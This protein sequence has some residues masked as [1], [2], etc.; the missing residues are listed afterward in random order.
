MRKSNWI[1]L[2]RKF[3]GFISFKWRLNNKI[4]IKNKNLKVNNNNNIS[5]KKIIKRIKKGN[6]EIISKLNKSKKDKNI[7]ALKVLLLNIKK[8]KK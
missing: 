5:N 8:F 2:I 1:K 7:K 4:K 6:G 3:K